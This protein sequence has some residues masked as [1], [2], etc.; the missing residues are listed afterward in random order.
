M[1]LLGTDGVFD[2]LHD[3]EATP[4]AFKIILCKAPEKRLEADTISSRSC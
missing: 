4:A 2:N 1:L 3:H